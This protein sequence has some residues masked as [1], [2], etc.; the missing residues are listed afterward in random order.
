MYFWCCL[1]G[2]DLAVSHC[3]SAE[4]DSSWQIWIP[5]QVMDFSLLPMGHLR[6]GGAARIQV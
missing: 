1:F 4:V 6:E 2:Q 5:P 3:C